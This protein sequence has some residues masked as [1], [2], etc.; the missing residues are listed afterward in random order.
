[1]P[2]D[3]RFPFWAEVELEKAPRISLVGGRRVCA[4]GTK[5]QLGRPVLPHRCRL[6]DRFLAPALGFHAVIHVGLPA[7]HFARGDLFLGLMHAGHFVLG[8]SVH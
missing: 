2:H 1:M 4:I 3:R 8:Q 6:V 5:A 7:I